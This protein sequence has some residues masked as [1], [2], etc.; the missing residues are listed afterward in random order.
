MK[1]VQLFLA[2]IIVVF[3]SC[4]QNGPKEPMGSLNGYECVDLGLSVKWA[5]MNVGAESPEQC[6]CFFAWG[7]TKVKSTYTYETYYYKHNN[8]PN[9]SLSNDA[10]HV[11]WGGRWR[12]PTEEDWKELQAY[13]TWEFTQQNGI[14][15]YKVASMANQNSIFL[16]V[17]GTPYRNTYAGSYIY[18]GRYW[19]SNFRDGGYIYL[20]FDEPNQICRTST[21]SGCMGMAVRPVCK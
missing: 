6:G 20:Y 9:L 10:A 4:E 11:H 21:S 19:S 17:T 3:A 16:P 1:R 7:E 5:T 18:P 14:Y 13:C 8:R 12:M 2:A 15:G